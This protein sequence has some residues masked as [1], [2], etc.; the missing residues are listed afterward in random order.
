MSAFYAC[1]I[2]NAVV[3]VAGEEV[4]LLDGS[5]Q[6]FVASLSEAVEQQAA[7]RPVTK[8]VKAL[9]VYDG[10]RWIKIRPWK[11]FRLEIQTYVKPFGRLPWWKSD[12]SRSDCLKEI[13]PAR[14]FGS[15]YQGLIAKLFTRMLPNPIC[16]GAN[17]SNTV[18]IS[19]GRVITPGGLR[20]PDEFVRHRALDL[21][22]DFML[23]GTDFQARFVCFS[24]THHLARKTLE[25][26]FT[27]PSVY[28][29]H[30]PHK[31]LPITS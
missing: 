28:F 24:P 11:T 17:S 18:V 22:G 6:P 9:S 26:I 23:A 14:T 27:N 21:I 30:G 8:I 25:A 7:T 19:R 3:D 2:D 20:Y 1:G 5:A 13:S 12:I 31:G 15:L 4:P 29:H 10:P 16:L